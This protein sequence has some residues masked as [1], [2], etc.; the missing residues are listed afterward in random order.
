MNKVKSNKLLQDSFWAIFGNI[1]SKGLSLLSGVLVA[2]FLGSEVF[3]QF[4]IIKNTLMTSAIFATFGLGYTATKYVAENK[5]KK[6][7]YLGIVLKYSQ[8]ITFGFSFILAFLVFIFSNYFAKNILDEIEL[9]LPLKVA[10]IYIVFNAVNTTQIGIISGYGG[11]KKMTK[12]NFYV[13]VFTFIITT[14]LS[15]FFTLYGAL[16]SLILSQIFN[17]FLNYKLINNY[18]KEY[19]NVTNSVVFSR[20]IFQEIL[21]FSLP[22]AL[23][24]AIYSISSWGVNIILVTFATFSEV[25][26]YSA[27]MQWNVIILFIPAILRNVILSHFSEN[28]NNEKQKN[29]ILKRIVLFNFLITFIPYILI[30]VFSGFISGFYGTSFSRMGD[31]LPVLVLSSVFLSMSNVYTQA[32]LS[33]SRNW[34]MLFLRI[35]RDLGI[36]IV[37]YMMVSNNFKNLP[38]SVLVALGIVVLNFLFFIIMALNYHTKIFLKWK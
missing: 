26:V 16:I 18:K 28:T 13:G 36:L 38:S 15:Y 7:E 21:I 23:Q 1:L 10:A 2:R 35:F 32:Y 4:G 25:G 31:V 11:F 37:C 17:W 9:S 3:G 34:E 24:E 19:K 8:L 12:I 5:T 30:V 27:A 22:I 20:K 14:I 6:N 33:S 29:K